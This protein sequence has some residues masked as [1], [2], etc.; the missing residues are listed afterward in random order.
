MATTTNYAWE[1]PDDTDLVKDGA[2]AIRTLGSSIDSTV[3]A[4][5]SASI[6]KTLIDAKGDLIG[7]T[8]A[9]TPAR[10]A[11]GTNGQVLTA[12]STA[13]TGLAWATPG[14]TFVGCS[15][16]AGAQSITN[17]VRTAIAFTSEAYDT[18]SFHDNATNN[19]RI[20]IPTGQGGKYLFTFS[21]HWTTGSGT[22]DLQLYKN[23][24]VTLTP[25]AAIVAQ[26]GSEVALNGSYVLNLVANDYIEVYGY[27]AG[28]GNETTIASTF[29]AT[30]VG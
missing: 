25:S 15:L 3:F 13:S 5:A 24:S 19:S 21:M 26:A 12:D 14:V 17:D 9:D 28:G 8:A 10:L 11:V 27:T 6:A 4:N 29:T 16:T 18:N 20:T 30:K 1:T 23:G 7:A 22:R 2:S